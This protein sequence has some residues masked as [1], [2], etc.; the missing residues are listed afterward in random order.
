[1]TFR[2]EIKSRE[3]RY[4]NDPDIKRWLS[5]LVTALLPNKEAFGY[6]FDVVLAPEV[7]NWCEE[8]LRKTIRSNCK[9]T[10]IQKPAHVYYSCYFIFDDEIDAMLFKMRWV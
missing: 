5:S 9:V 3:F 2:I 1:M 10:V 4:Y 8:N 7:V 6:D